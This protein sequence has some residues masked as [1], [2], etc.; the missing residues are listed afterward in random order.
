M[1]IKLRGTIPSP[2]NPPTGCRFHTRC[3]LY[4]GDICRAEAPPWQTTEAGNRY[5]CHIPPAELATAE[6]QLRER[7]TADISAVNDQIA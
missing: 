7:G 5:R 3:P 1:R 2:S 4:L 6:Q